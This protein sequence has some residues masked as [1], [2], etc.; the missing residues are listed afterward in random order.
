MF[1]W[2]KHPISLKT[3]LFLSTGLLLH[4]PRSSLWPCRQDA[5]LLEAISHHV[6]IGFWCSGLSPYTL[7][8][9]LRS[10]MEERKNVLD[11]NPKELS[12]STLSGPYQLF[13]LRELVHRFW[14]KWYS[15]NP[16][17]LMRQYTGIII[18]IWKHSLNC[19][20]QFTWKVVVPPSASG[21]HG[22]LL[23]V[24]RILIACLPFSWFMSKGPGLPSITSHKHIGFTSNYSFLLPLLLPVA[25][26]WPLFLMENVPKSWLLNSHRH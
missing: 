5:G 22:E 4:F 14:G 12:S 3:Q 11:P 9:T 18:Y 1:V 23:S 21:I 6:A 19:K 2:E 13:Y 7:G 15:A 24:A 8:Y 20:V 25:D 17:E 10:I 16:V 26:H